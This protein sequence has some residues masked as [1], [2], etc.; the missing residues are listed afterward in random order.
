MPVV[1]VI[2]LHPHY[3]VGIIVPIFPYEETG[4]EVKESQ[5]R[6][7][8]AGFHRDSQPL[9]QCADLSWNAGATPMSLC[10]GKWMHQSVDIWLAGS[11]LLD[12]G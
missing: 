1:C 7:V 10:S 2:I 5:L 12:Q 3:K 9:S 4:L 8:R 6:K 11:H